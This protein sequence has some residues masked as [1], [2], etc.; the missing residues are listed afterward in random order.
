M[1]ILH[2]MCLYAE[3]NVRFLAIAD[4]IDT[5]QM[6]VSSVPLFLS[7]YYCSPFSLG[8]IFKTLKGDFNI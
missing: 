4:G 6:L 5:S 3:G 8:S 2:N 1:F 7:C